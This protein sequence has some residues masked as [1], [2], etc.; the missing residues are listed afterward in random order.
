MYVRS[1][2]SVP[3]ATRSLLAGRLGLTA[4]LRCLDGGGLV[5]W[6]AW[7]TCLYRC[8]TDVFNFL[9]RI[10]GITGMAYKQ[11]WYLTSSMISND[12]IR[13]G[14]SQAKTF[15]FFF[16]PVYPVAQ[17]TPS[18]NTQKSCTR[19]ELRRAPLART[20]T[21][22]LASHGIW[23]EHCKHNPKCAKMQ[24]RV[25]NIRI[26]HAQGLCTS[27]VLGYHGQIIRARATG[28][29][30]GL[31]HPLAWYSHGPKSV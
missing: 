27:I 29:P 22:N 13:S 8:R 11:R 30:I 23:A 16:C 9:F 21:N 28:L 31:Y 20:K 7:A 26:K 3:P 24:C 18:Q 14:I 2:L 25:I 5:T 1:G 6:M 10:L 12:R 4:Q 15:D 17:I 19:N